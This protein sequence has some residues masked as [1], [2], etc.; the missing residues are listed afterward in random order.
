MR[1]S[2]VINQIQVPIATNYRALTRSM[3]VS[4][5]VG[6]DKYILAGES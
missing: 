5:V 3:N 4:Y 1:C 6:D 2:G